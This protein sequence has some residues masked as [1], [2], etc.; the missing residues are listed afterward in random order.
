MFCAH[1]FHTRSKDHA[2]YH[3]HS[4][5]S[6]QYILLHKMCLCDKGIVWGGVGGWERGGSGAD[7]LPGN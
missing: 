2:L 7:K 6:A 3:T 5:V 4:N 1:C